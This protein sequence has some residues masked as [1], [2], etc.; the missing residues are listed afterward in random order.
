MDCGEKGDFMAICKWLFAGLAWVVVV[1]GPAHAAPRDEMTP[2][3]R[4]IFEAVIKR[5]GSTFMAGD[6]KRRDTRKQIDRQLHAEHPDWKLL[7]R[8]IEQDVADQSE[9]RR[10][11]RDMQKQLLARLPET[12]RL[13]YLRWDYPDSSTPPEIYVV[14]KPQPGQQPPAP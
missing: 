11:S 5:A 14:P 7:N 10:A 1:Q 9:M 12:D 8:L 6:R 4:A 2:E 3:G 13:I